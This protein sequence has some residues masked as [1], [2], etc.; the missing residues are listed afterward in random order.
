MDQ[1]VQGWKYKLVKFGKKWIMSRKNDHIRHIKLLKWV[2]QLVFEHE[3]SVRVQGFLI[4]ERP[5]RGLLTTE[6]NLRIRLRRLTSYGD[7]VP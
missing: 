2:F 1:V 3:H 6:R 7:W 4:L 5:S